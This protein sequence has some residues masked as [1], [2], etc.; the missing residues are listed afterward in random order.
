[1]TTAGIFSSLRQDAMA[2]RGKARPYKDEGVDGS[3]SGQTAAR[4]GQTPSLGSLRPWA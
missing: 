2:M 1:M 3:T 4:A